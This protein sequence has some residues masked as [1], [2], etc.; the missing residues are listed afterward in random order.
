MITMVNVLT[1]EHHSRII[2]DLGNVCTTAGVQPRFMYQ[3]MK[4]HCSGLEVEWVL[5]F[6]QHL[7]TGL[8]GL[9]LNGVDHPDTR[10]QAI[11]AALV[12]NYIDARVIP[13]NTVLE[14]HENGE[15]VSPTVLLIPNLYVHSVGK[16]LPSWKVQVLYDLL[17]ARSV[18]SKPT[19]VY[20]E[21]LKATAATYGKPFADFLEGFLCI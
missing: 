20:V 8:P 4:E 11:A 19:V 14:M 12:R 15:M 9:V 21:D 6:K 1:Q 3:S 16:N 17:L 2:A 18:Q 13:L 5:H 10:C 7:A